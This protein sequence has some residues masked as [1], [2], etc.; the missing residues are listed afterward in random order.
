[1][2]DGQFFRKEFHWAISRVPGAEEEDVLMEEHEPDPFRLTQGVLGRLGARV[3][4]QLT[5]LHLP[6]P[7]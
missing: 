2:N 6:R 3:Q 4:R 1:M 5:S 7:P